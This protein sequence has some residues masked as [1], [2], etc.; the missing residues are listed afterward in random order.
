VNRVKE[1]IRKERPVWTAWLAVVGM[2]VVLSTLRAPENPAEQPG[3]GLAT[4]ILWQGLFFGYVVFLVR[5]IRGTEKGPNFKP[6]FITKTLGAW[7][8]VWRSLV[9]AWLTAPL[10][11]M[12]FL[13][14]GDNALG[15]TFTLLAML[16][17]PPVL[18]WVVFGWNRIAT[19][20]AY[21]GVRG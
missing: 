17:G 4:G 11:V 20:K 8:Y 16:F 14:V 9:V 1:L 18:C 7:G 10:A 21:L 15:V 3:T 5:Y 19:I 6:P 13:F 2:F 12:L